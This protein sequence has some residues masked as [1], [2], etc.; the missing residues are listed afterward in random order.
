MMAA[1]QAVN[2]ATEAKRV[3][4]VV[5]GGGSGGSGGGGHGEGSGGE[6]A[7]RRWRR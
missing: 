2:V 3:A 4:G 1:V 5:A 6:G 7:Q